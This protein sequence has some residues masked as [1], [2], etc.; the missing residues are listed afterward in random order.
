MRL[1]GLYN[2]VRSDRDIMAEFVKASGTGALADFADQYDC[3][4]T[5]SEIRD[6]FIAKCGGE[7]ELDDD[8][9]E[10]VSGGAF[11]FFAWIGNL[12]N[13]LFGG[14][15]SSNTSASTTTKNSVIGGGIVNANND[16]PRSSIVGKGIAPASNN[17]SKSSIYKKL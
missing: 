6:Y 11:D 15:G 8:A 14:A 2:K 7:G 9:V 3:H 4:A 17:I 12:F 16:L 1:E 13:S 10:A 5:D